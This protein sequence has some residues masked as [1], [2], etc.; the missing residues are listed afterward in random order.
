MKE[1]D[2]FMKTVIHIAPSHSIED[3]RVFYRECV[4]LS[5][6]YAVNL[7]CV[8]GET[9]E[10]VRDGVHIFQIK[11]KIFPF[12]LIQVFFTAIRLS[13][14]VY[15][16]HEVDSLILS[17]LLKAFRWDMKIIFDVHEYFE[18][19]ALD[20][21]KKLNKK[22]KAWF[23]IYAFLLKPILPR[24][25]NGIVTISPLMKERYYRLNQNIEI[26]Y[27]YPKSSLLD[28]IESNNALD[29]QYDYLVYHGGIKEDRG[30]MLYPRLLSALE[31][32]RIRLLV[33]GR[34]DKKLKIKFDDLC[35]ELGIEHQVITTGYL[36]YKGLIGYLKN[37][38]RYVGLTL[39][40][41]QEDHKKAINT[42]VFE[43]LYISI[44]QIGSDY[45]IYFR[46]YVL[47]NKVGIGAD[48]YDL[49][50]QIKAVKTILSNYAA[51]RNRCFEIRNDYLWET[52]ERKLLQFY[53][54]L[55]RK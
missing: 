12:F 53:R 32:E 25:C 50:T 31:D 27:N 23:K 34:F 26:L 5:K 42:K 4:S 19:Y 13:G 11:K 29:P 41:Y 9:K 7:I 37:N 16:V 6:E 1:L 33:I 30:I 15:H 39:F 24:F 45:R 49:E 38:V 40:G 10:F 17:F 18:D 8:G 54:N 28:E 44:P 43:Y 20:D 3:A 2:N 51:F 55:L 46:K 47:E 36:P 48:Y 52:E 21:R 14:E 22:A 35:K